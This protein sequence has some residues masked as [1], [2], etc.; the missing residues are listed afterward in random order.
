M[1]ANVEKLD[2]LREEINRV[3]ESRR[4]HVHDEY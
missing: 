3:G 1:A 2:K 4:W